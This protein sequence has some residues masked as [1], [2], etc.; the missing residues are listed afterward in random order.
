[1]LTKAAIIA[2][3]TLQAPKYG[4]EPELALA[5]VE[6][7]SQFNVNA[8]SYVGAI[9]LFQIMPSSQP[10]YTPEEIRKP[11]IN[12]KLGLKMLAEYRKSCIHK[13]G[14]QFLVCYNY[15]P[16][17]AKKVKHPDQFPYVKKIHEILQRTKSNKKHKITP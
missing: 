11:A 15:G 4:I 1:M 14:L 8:T 10:N 16:A 3:I 17:N 5:V 6:H 2:I 12:I 9:G 13:S 7:E